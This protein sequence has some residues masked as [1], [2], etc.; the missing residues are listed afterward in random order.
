MVPDA[1]ALDAELDLTDLDRRVLDHYLDTLRMLSERLQVIDSRIMEISET[2][3]YREKVKRLRSFRGFSALGAM[4]VV[5]EVME[6]TRFPSA[7]CFH[8]VCR[9]GPLGILLLGPDPPGADHQGGQ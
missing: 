6:F 3:T 9:A 2:D 7:P 1:L 5:A 4:R 8:E